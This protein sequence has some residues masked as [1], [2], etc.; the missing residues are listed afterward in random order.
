MDNAEIKKKSCFKHLFLCRQTVN[1]PTKIRSRKRPLRAKY[2]NSTTPLICTHNYV[3]KKYHEQQDLLRKNR[4]AALESLKITPFIFP[5]M[6]KN[7]HWNSED[8]KEDPL[9]T[10]VT[11]RNFPNAQSCCLNKNTNNIMN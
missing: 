2:H 6:S 5:L 8:F 3:K 7:N 4:V 1:K 11:T 9:K 10:I